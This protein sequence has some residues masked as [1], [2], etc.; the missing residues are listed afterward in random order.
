MMARGAYRFVPRPVDTGH[1]H[2]YLVFDG[3]D[4]LHFHLTVFA[5]EATA[6][7]SESTLRT[8][9]YAVLPFFT[10]LD[11][12]PWQQRAGCQWDASPDDVRQAIDDYLVQHLQCKVR[13]H[14][15]GFQ[16]VSITQGT[17]ST[18]HVLL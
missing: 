16:L 9:L 2:P 8:Y 11:T 5:K 10:F 17:R 12:D 4:R 14:R 15:Q 3:Q 1:Q 18:I 7:L 13:P 6:Q